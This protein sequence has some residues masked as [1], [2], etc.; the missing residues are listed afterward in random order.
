MPDTWR[1]PAC[2][3]A[4]L[5]SRAYFWL[6]IWRAHVYHCVH[7]RTPTETVCGHIAH[8][9]LIDLIQEV[10]NRDF[11]LMGDFN[12]KG[13]DWI[14]NCC[15][16]S[17]V[18]SKLFLECVNKCLVTQ[19]VTDLT[20]DSYSL[21]DLVLVEIPEWLI[22]FRLTVVSILVAINRLVSI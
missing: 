16:N 14:N 10:R 9:Q 8:E 15:N 6:A 3:V 20:T 13:I 21:L 19:H 4:R 11:I 2:A 12:Y 1:R 22:I 17:S 5:L 18:D 7:Y